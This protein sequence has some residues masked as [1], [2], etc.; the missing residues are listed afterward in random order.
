MVKTQGVI[1]F[2]LPATD[3]ERS[4]KFYS[5]SHRGGGTGIRDLHERHHDNGGAV[6][7]GECGDDAGGDAASVILRF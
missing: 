4:G 2:S 7:H 5:D 1:H 3:L 6:V